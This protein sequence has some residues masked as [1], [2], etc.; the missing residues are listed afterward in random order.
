MKLLAGQM[1]NIKTNGNPGSEVWAVSRMD[2]TSSSASS[3]S[4][5]SAAFGAAVVVVFY[6]GPVS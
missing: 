2:A 6:L 4:A 1:F 3:S 5:S